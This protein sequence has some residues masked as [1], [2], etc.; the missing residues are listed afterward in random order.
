MLKNSYSY[1]IFKIVLIYL[2]R[3]KSYAWI[4]LY[5]VRCGENSIN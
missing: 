3:Q 5:I 1:K 2:Y 4:P